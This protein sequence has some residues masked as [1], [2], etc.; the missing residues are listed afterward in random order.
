VEDLLEATMEPVERALRDARLDAG[1]I[2]AVLLVGGSSRIPLVARLVEARFGRPPRREVH[3]EEAIALGAA[4]QAGLKSGALDASGLVVTDVCPHTLGVEVV[5]PGGEAGGPGAFSP[6]I[7]R[8]T[9]VPVSRTETY[10]TTADGQR[11]VE[12]RV[13]Q[14]EGRHVRDN[15]LLDHYVIDGI[16]PGPAGAERIAV[17]FTYDINGILRV[18][19]RV[20]STGRAATLE[21]VR[22]RTG[23]GGR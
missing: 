9:T 7:A 14:G 21:V 5:G 6:I 20:L 10:A 18:E 11:H 8:N 22:H 15:L 13:Y 12:I 17:S 3:P 16:P 19:T 4:I 23:S 2:D 1:R